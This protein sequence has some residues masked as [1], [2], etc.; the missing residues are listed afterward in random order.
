MIFEQVRNIALSL[1]EVEESTSY[2]T[3]AFKVRK[4]LVLRL[5][6]DSER[7]VINCSEFYRH[8]LVEENPDAFS[9]PPHYQNYA[10]VVV[11][12]ETVDIK[13]FRELL[14]ESWRIVAP[15]KVLEMEAKKK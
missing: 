10:M 7:V 1:P 4:K 9:I 12:L 13:E 8:A 2:G 3:P 11:R 6:E 15:K 14:R 5:L